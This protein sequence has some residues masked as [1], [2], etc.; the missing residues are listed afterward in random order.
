MNLNIHCVRDA[1]DWGEKL[2][3]CALLVM[4][5]KSTNYYYFL[6]CLSCLKVF[7]LPEEHNDP[8]LSSL[9]FVF[10]CAGTEKRTRIFFF[11]QPSLK[12][13]LKL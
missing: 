4:V 12:G 8:D 13:M 11:S 2:S 9:V 1:L 5:S 10:C 3:S 7:L 6:I